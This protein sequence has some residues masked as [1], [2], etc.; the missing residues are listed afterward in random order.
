MPP[1]P[2]C[3]PASQRPPRVRLIPVLCCLVTLA[4]VLLLGGCGRPRGEV[5]VLTAEPILY[6]YA[7]YF[8]AQQDDI[9]I[10]VAYAENPISF[11]NQ[12]GSAPDLIIQRN[13]AGSYQTD[14][15][16]TLD[17]SLHPETYPQLADH[18]RNE[19][20]SRMLPLSFSLPMIVWHEQQPGGSLPLTIGLQQLAELTETAQ[21]NGRLTHIGFA[22]VWDS[23][24]LLWHLRAHQVD[25]AFRQPGTPAWTPE[26]TAA[27]VDEVRGWMD[28]TLGSREEL[29]RF[30]DTYLYIPY[31]ALLRQGRIDYHPAD[32]REF[33]AL[34][35]SLRRELDFAWFGSNGRIP[36]PASIIYGAIPRRSDNPRAA[37]HFLEWLSQPENQQALIAYTLDQQLPEF[38][39]FGGFSALVATNEQTIPATFREMQGKAPVASR[40]QFPAPMPWYWSSLESQILLPFLVDSV[41]QEEPPA[42]EVLPDRIESWLSRLGID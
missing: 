33:F 31:Y 42:P 38:G 34:P 15:F 2:A 10:D 8:N 27:A 18:F 30:N 4:V 5:R 9:Y 21:S 20:K 3:I 13:P 6:V 35:S 37:R 25:L 17:I 14:W 1:I 36:V 12:P 40:L 41:V 16:R 32:L 29:A 19:T 11:R 26:E 24:V 23:R 22:P 39:F 28:E 7:E